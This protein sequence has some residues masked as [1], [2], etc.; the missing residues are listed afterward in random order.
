MSGFAALDMETQE[1]LHPGDLGRRRRRPTPRSCEVLAAAGAGPGAPAARPS[2]TCAP[3]GSTDVPCVAGVR[4]DV[5]GSAAPGRR[6]VAVCAGLLRPEFLLEVFPT[7]V[8]RTVT[9]LSLLTDELRAPGRP[10]RRRTPR[11]SRWA[12]PRSATSRSPSATT[13]RSTPT[14]SA[15][16]RTATTASSRRR[17]WS[18]RPTSTSTCPRDDDGFAGHGWGI[19]MPGTR[20]V[21]G[22]NAYRFHQPVRPTTSSPRPGGS[23]TS[24]SA[25]PGRAAGCS[26]S[27][28]PRPF[29]EPARRRCW[30]R[31]RRR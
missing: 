9:R 2:S 7:A 23:P 3:S 20:L 10:R 31:T 11:P 4:R 14:T 25:P 26:S 22:G 5:L 18:A 21:R 16:G 1:A 19:E 13:T 15:P 27:P 29:T 6:P 30:S 28:R 12:A 24:P 17:R 8:L